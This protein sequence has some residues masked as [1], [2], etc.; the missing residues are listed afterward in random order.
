MVQQAGEP[1]LLIAI[2]K[3]LARIAVVPYAAP[4]EFVLIAPA[5]QRRAYRE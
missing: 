1:L 2:A 5:K 3:L 4:L